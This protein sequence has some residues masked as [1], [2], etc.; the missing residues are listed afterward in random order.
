M[1]K[2]SEYVE[3]WNRGEIKLDNGH[4]RAS[5]TRL[6]SGLYAQICNH[7]SHGLPKKW[8]DAWPSIKTA[9]LTL[10]S[11]SGLL[12]SPPLGDLKSQELLPLPGQA[13][14]L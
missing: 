13:L 8:A 10:S 1:G 2:V 7:G 5:T 4:D 14:T 6:E 12:P 3:H 11:A 9:A